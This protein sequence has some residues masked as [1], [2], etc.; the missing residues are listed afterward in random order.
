M[1]KAKKVVKLKPCPFCGSKP[2]M[3]LPYYGFNWEIR[4]SRCGFGLRKESETGCV[5]AWN[6]RYK[7]SVESYDYT[8]KKGS[9]TEHQWQISG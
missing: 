1:A 6:K 2:N 5:K 4:C 7:G 8:M 9:G 3:P